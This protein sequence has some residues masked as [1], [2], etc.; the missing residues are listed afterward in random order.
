M[1]D[2]GGGLLLPTCKS[3]IPKITKTISPTLR[4]KQMGYIVWALPLI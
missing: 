4:K 1:A 2:I 3:D